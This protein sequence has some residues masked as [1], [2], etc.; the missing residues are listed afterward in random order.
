MYPSTNGVCPHC[1]YC[2][3]CGQ[4][5]NQPMYPYYPNVTC[6]NDTSKTSGTA[7]GTYTG[8]HTP[9]LNNFQTGTQDL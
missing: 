4:Q 2:P 8:T 7:S 6:T 1:G 3:H 9:N 5:R